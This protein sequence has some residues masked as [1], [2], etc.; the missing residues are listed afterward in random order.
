[1]LSDEFVKSIRYSIDSSGKL[2]VDKAK[3]QFES[4]SQQK[5]IFEKLGIQKNV[6]V[7]TIH[8]SKGREFDGV[9]LVL[10]DRNGM[11]KSSSTTNT[12]EIKELYNVAISR[13]K[14]AISIVA[15]EDA[16]NAASEPAKRLLEI[17]TNPV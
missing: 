12:E 4:T 8:K 5:I 14:K 1:M 15:F 16:I 6:Q 2:D 13:A 9:V 7:M 11:W 3:K 10:E 17:S